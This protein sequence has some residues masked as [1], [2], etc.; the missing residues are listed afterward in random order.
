MNMSDRT[1]ESRMAHAFGLEGGGWQRHT[2]PWSVYTRIP[3]P[4]MLALAVWSRAWIGWWCLAPIALVCFWAAINPQAFPPPASADRWASKA[5]LGET[6]WVRRNTVPIPRHHVRACQLL[7]ALN[8]GGVPLVVWGLVVLDVWLVVA[9]LVIHMTG[10]NWFLDRMVWLYQ[11]MTGGNHPRPGV[12]DEL[13]G[14]R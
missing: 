5:V 12:P 9:G 1:A 10:K 3:I 7:L 2:N 6:F 8:V 13:L 4:A 14:G 11:D